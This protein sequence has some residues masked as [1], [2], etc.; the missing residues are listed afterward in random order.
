[1][2]DMTTTQDGLYEVAAREYAAALKRLA[3]AY[4]A[5]PE[6]CRDLLQDIHVALWRSFANFNGACSTRTWI[7]RIAHNAAISHVVRERR[8][9]APVVLGLEEIEGM[10]APESAPDNNRRQ[11]LAQLLQMVRQLKPI[12]R[13]VILAYLEDMDAREI[14]EI[15]GLSP[16]NVATKIYRIKNI[17]AVRF[18]TGGGVE[19]EH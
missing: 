18:R 7:F 8:R 12:D 14:A 10:P 5:D 17:M 13:E 3:R 1:M 4:E 6:K 9:N 2:S 15:T 19:R 11:R 16:S